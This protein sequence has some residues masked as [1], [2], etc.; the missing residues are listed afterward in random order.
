MFFTLPQSP[1]IPVASLW[2]MA[3]AFFQMVELNGE[4]N[5]IFFQ[6]LVDKVDQGGNSGDT[7]WLVPKGSLW[8]Q[9]RGPVQGTP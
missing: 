4:G 3:D 5:N 1:P 9:G 2:P 7:E 8:L 6:T